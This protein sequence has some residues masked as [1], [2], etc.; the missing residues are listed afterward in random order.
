M[1]KKTKAVKATKMKKEKGEGTKK[2][3]A[4]DKKNGGE[5]AEKKLATLMTAKSTFKKA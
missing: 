4:F 1:M 2:E 5:K 3:E